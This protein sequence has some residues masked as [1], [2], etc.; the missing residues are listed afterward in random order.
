[1]DI[2][3][4]PLKRVDA[5]E[6]TT[7]QAKYTGDLVPRNALV[8]KVLHSTIGN[9]IVKSFDLTEAWKVPDIVDIVT[10]FDVPDIQFPTAGHPWS[11]DKKHQDIADRKLLNTRVRF[12]GDDIAAVI[13]ENELAERE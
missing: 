2:I 9:G 1:M 6:K 12:Y 7:G 8:A 13:D 11:T 10:C 5:K 4:A 3:G